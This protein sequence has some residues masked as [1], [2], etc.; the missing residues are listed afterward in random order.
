MFNFAGLDEQ[1]ATDELTEV[2]AKSL[3][4]HISKDGVEF[5]CRLGRLINTKRRIAP[6]ILT[7]AVVVSEKGTTFEASVPQAVLEA[8]QETLFAHASLELTGKHD[9]TDY[10]YRDGRRL[11]VDN[12]TKRLVHEVIKEKFSRVDVYCPTGKFDIRFAVAVEKASHTDTGSGDIAVVPGDYHTTRHKQR[13]SYHFGDVVIDLTVATMRRG[14]EAPVASHEVEVE[15]TEAALRRCREG[16]V[17]A[18][19]ELCRGVVRCARYVASLA[20]VSD[21]AEED[22]SAKRTKTS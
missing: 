11:S 3:A 14:A 17:D 5:E 15:V 13:T 2:L 9:V 18:L 21:R 10:V 1:G 19:R 7:P 6:P 8:L 4:P 22:N 12:V 20:T 16:G